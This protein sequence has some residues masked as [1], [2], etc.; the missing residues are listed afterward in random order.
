M[1][2]LV[3]AKIVGFT[4]LL[5]TYSPASFAITEQNAEH[6]CFGMGIFL[7]ALATLLLG[8]Y[9]TRHYRLKYQKIL[10]Q[11]KLAKSNVKIAEQTMV[12]LA[13][14]QQDSQDLLEERVQERTLELNIA[15]QELESAN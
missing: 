7:G 2:L 14:E 15:L 6:L 12:T 1:K 8:L 11:L 3:K 5:I 13:K 10:Q 9:L 4:S